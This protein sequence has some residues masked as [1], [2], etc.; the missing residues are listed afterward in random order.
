MSLYGTHPVDKVGNGAISTRIASIK[1]GCMGVMGR[2]DSSSREPSQA[3]KEGKDE[4]HVE[5]KLG[6]FAEGMS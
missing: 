6:W 5:G 1:L 2:N 4:S 3:Q